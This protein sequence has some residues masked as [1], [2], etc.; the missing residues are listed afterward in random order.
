MN[1]F[2]SEMYRAAQMSQGSDFK[3]WALQQSCELEG[4][5]SASWVNGVMRDG[6]PIFHDSCT[7]GLAPGY[8]QCMQSLAAI[9]PLGPKMFASP[10]T[11]YVTCYED[12]PP[13]IVEQVMKAYKVGSAVSGMV[14]SPGTGVF[15]VVCWHR[16]AST[17]PFSSE[18]RRLHEQLLPHWIECLTISRVAEALRDL[19]SVA[20]SGYLAALADS[21]GLLHYAQR[22]FGESLHLEFPD[23]SGSVLPSELI[24]WMQL[25]QGI[26]RGNQIV[27]DWRATPSGLRLLHIRTKVPSDTLT[28]REQQVVQLLAQGSS[29]KRVAQTLAISPSTVD[30]L[31]AAAYAKL[32]VRNRAQLALSIEPLATGATE[33]GERDR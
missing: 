11:S 21:E 31:R 2:I 15:S 5:H 6:V 30:N 3:S 7:V 12:F 25:T 16:D 33:A 8:W 32:N 20:R 29:V 23:W 17:P 24:N 4:L 9:D 13:P 26:H 28:P 10:G 27:A 1:R 19:G 18:Q 22:G 14:C